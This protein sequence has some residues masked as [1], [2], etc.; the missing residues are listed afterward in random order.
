[1][2]AMSS[3][4]TMWLLY[5]FRL[6]TIYKS[7]YVYATKWKYNDNINQQLKQHDSQ[8]GDFSSACGDWQRNTRQSNAI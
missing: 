2:F 8:D 1:M 6:Y 5:V 7:L 4:E 3:N